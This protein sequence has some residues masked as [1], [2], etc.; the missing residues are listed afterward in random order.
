M[1]FKVC[2]L[3]NGFLCFVEEFGI[4]FLDIIGNF[5]YGL[6]FLFGKCFECKRWVVDQFEECGE[7]EFLQFGVEVFGFIRMW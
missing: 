1:F 2:F 6:V 3:V 7:E 5:L 4:V